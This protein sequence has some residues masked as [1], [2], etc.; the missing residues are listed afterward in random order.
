MG[1]WVRGLLLRSMVYCA[2]SFLLGW[3]AC[4]VNTVLE[5][6]VP[7]PAWRHQQGCCLPA[8]SHPPY[9]P[10]PIPHS[11][12][13]P[14]LP[15]SPRDAETSE[16]EE[17]VENLFGTLCSCLMLP[18][19]KRAFVE[20]EGIELM[21]LVLKGRRAH[22]TAALKVLDFAT[23]RCPPACERLVDQQGLKTLFAIFM[24]KLKVGGGGQG[25]VSRAS[26]RVVGG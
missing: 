20:S 12:P 6:L 18:E 17:L 8:F 11:P 15:S 22:R 9:P 24:G 13:P 7:L 23:T 19:N 2:A 1:G 10:F 21:L 5:G 16:E 3:G 26:A 14:F 25:G 4:V